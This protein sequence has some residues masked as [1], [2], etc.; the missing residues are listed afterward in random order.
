M[1]QSQSVA[2]S[3]QFFT[4]ISYDFLKIFKLTIYI[5]CLS[6]YKMLEDF[7]PIFTAR[8]IKLE[9]F[10]LHHITFIFFCSKD[11]SYSEDF[12]FHSLELLIHHFHTYF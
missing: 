10:S 12:N 7:I 3:Q 1:R 4:K 6:A 5:Y 8:R 11:I 2:I 9:Q